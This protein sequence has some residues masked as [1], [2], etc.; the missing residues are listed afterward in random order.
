M[1]GAD[2]RGRLPLRRLRALA[3]DTTPLR[4]PAYRRLWLGQ[5]VTIVGSQMTLVA[6]PAQVFF[7]THRS[8][9]VG[10]TS[11]VALVPLVVFGLLGGAIADAVDRRVLLLVT[12]SALAVVSALL[13]VQALL[14]GAGNIYLL[15]ALVAVQSGL[16]AVNSPARSAVIPRLVPAEQV[17]AANAL[18]QLVMN[19]GVVAGPLAAGVVIERAGLPWTYLLDASSFLF[20]LYSLLRLPPLPP[21][22]DGATGRASVREGLRFLAGRRILMMTFLV[23]INAMVF[24]W[25][26]ALFP[27]LAETRFGGQGALG[28]LYAAP[29]LGAL[30]SGV[31]GGWLGRVNRQGLAVLVSV[32]LWGGAIAVFGV[33]GSLP[34]AVLCLAGAGAADMVSAVFR[35]SMLQVAAP[36]AMR[37]RLQGVFIVVVT[38]GPRLGDMRAGGMSA[39]TSPTASLV[40]G[41]VVCVLGVLLLT[42]AVPAFARYQARRPSAGLGTEL[43][44]VA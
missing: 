11:V 34:L 33:V 36:D 27:E 19:A 18:N 37:G 15:W 22:R 41:G 14:P 1:T 5:A 9:D 7:L 42:L 23:D 44:A 12:G 4:A 21:E 32:C 26:R 30:V 17:P 25:P 29:A 39:L 10:L 2:T 38:G 43:D 20:A 3:V 40:S 13:W 35:T 16:V 24:G 8:L 31:F 6:V 28:W